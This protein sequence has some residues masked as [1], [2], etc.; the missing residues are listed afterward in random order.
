[1][2]DDNRP[3]WDANYQRRITPEDVLAILGRSPQSRADFIATR[4][5]L[6]EREARDYAAMLTATMFRTMQR[7]TPVTEWP[8]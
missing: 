7:A 1:M 2:D 3:V 6:A 8:W 4:D 5:L